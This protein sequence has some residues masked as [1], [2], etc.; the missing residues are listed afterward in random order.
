MN[1]NNGL[2]SVKIGQILSSIPP[3]EWVSDIGRP[4]LARQIEFARHYVVHENADK[5]CNLAGYSSKYCRSRSQELVVRCSP[6]I[7]KVRDARLAAAAEAAQ[8][9]EDEW[10][11]DVKKLISYGLSVAASDED[12]RM[13]DPHVAA[14]GLELMGKSQG[15]FSET[16]RHAGQQVTFNLDYGVDNSRKSVAEAIEH[17]AE[18]AMTLGVEDR[19]NNT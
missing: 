2:N 8:D 3:N 7:N 18:S 13:L 1:A 4:L 5:A 11:R 19:L 10:E 17:E 16:V 14:R 6:I 15:R 12:G 9:D